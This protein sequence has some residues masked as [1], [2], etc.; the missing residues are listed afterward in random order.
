MFS[1]EKCD[2]YSPSHPEF[3]EMGRHDDLWSLFYMLVEFL[4]GSL[5][6]RKVKDKD[7]VGRMK[8][9][10]LPDRLLEGCPVEL[11]DFVRHLET[12]TYPDNPD[13]DYLGRCLKGVLARSV[14]NSREM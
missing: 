3:Q 5:P 2:D 14:R 6:W 11:L 4:H 12:L 8:E 9:E 10:I 7:E 1:G 13:F